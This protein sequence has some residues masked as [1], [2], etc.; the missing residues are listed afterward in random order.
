LVVYHNFAPTDRL[1]PKK[2]FTFH[3]RYISAVR[4]NH[5]SRHITVIDMTLHTDALQQIDIIIQID[6]LQQLDIVIQTEKGRETYLNQ[7]AG[8]KGNNHVP[9][10]RRIGQ[11]NH[12][13]NS[14]PSLT[15]NP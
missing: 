4:C 2:Y 10:N 1:H 12:L 8:D 11:P 7:L 13:P 15:M 9:P 3:N 14:P 5:S 6:A